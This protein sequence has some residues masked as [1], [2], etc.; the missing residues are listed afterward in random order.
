MRSLSSLST[1]LIA[2]C[3]CS[4]LAPPVTSLLPNEAASAPPADQR[5]GAPAALVR[6]QQW[7]QSWFEGTPVV[8][9]RAGDGA[10]LIE[11]P[12]VSCFDRGRSMVKPPLAVVLDKLAESLRRVP[13]AQL[14]LIAAPGDDAGVESL[15]LERAAQVRKYLLSR[16]VPATRL[17][18]P[19]TTPAAA[20][21]LRMDSGLP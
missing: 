19:I 17:G 16:G 14:S 21:Q 3:G 9:G 7:L 11:V 4:T 13:T 18:K 10:V 1:V 2:I 5:A 20:V 15:A 8:I 12:R 6:E